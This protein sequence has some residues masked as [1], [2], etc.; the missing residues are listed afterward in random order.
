MKYEEFMKIVNYWSYNDIVAFLIED[1]KWCD[2]IMDCIKSGWNEEMSKEITN[3][4]IAWF[5][6]DNGIMNY[7]AL[8]TEEE[9]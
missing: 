2:Y 4:E 8:P 7:T 9:E 5:A 1:I 3:Q 6:N